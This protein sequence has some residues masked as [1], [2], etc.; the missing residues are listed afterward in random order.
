MKLGAQLYSLRTE[1]DTPE[2]LLSTMHRLKE[3][4]YEVAQASAIC[5][6]EAERLLSYIQETGLPVSVTHTSFDKIVNETAKT[7]AF[8]KTI[9][10][11]VIGI[12]SMPTEYHGSLEGLK[13]FVKIVETPVKM[14]RDAGLR[15]AYHNHHFE[16]DMLDGGVTTYDYMLSEVPD[17]DFIHDVYWSKYAGVDTEKYIKLIMSE[18]RM[19]DI[20]YKDMRT[21]PKGEIC[22]VGDGVIDFVALTK[23][24]ATLGVKNVQIEQDNAP[25]LGDVFEQMERS[26]RHV[27]PIIKKYS[28]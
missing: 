25:E 6:I 3:I 11:P 26:F 1:C 4:G 17:F 27:F 24:C 5:E 28:E 14:I 19:T 18:G 16:F 8:H 10:C 20:H 23:L 21:E 15:F 13:A 7:I 22:P 9:G 2:K 12:G